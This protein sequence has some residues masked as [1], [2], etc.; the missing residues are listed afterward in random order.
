MHIVFGLVFGGFLAFMVKQY[1][2]KNAIYGTIAGL[3]S[4]GL[5]L[6]IAEISYK[7]LYL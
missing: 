7:M 3:V 4:C 1:G 6:V 2:L 5:I